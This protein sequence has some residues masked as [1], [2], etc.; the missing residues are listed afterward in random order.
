MNNNYWSYLIIRPSASPVLLLAGSWLLIGSLVL[1]RSLH[2][3]PKCLFSENL[4]WCLAEVRL[5]WPPLLWPVRDLRLKLS[6]DSYKN[7]SWFPSSPWYIGFIITATGWPRKH[8]E[9]SSSRESALWCWV[10]Y[11][12]LEEKKTRTLR[13]VGFET[14]LLRIYT[15]AAAIFSRLS[16]L[17]CGFKLESTI[18]CVPSLS[19]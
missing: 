10:H 5:F 11:I 9:S 18:H 4:L 14:R 1:H 19:I 3:R 15:S 6:R 16:I 7:S 2:Y 12:L 13:L 17:S 8:F